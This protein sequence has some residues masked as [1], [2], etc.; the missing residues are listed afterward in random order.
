MKN[1]NSNIFSELEF[2]HHYQLNSSSETV[3]P[4]DKKDVS[5]QATTAT[6]THTS[7]K[8]IIAALGFIA[9]LLLFSG[10]QLYRSLNLNP[11]SDKIR[12]SN[13][14]FISNTKDFDTHNLKEE[15][16]L[17]EFDNFIDLQKNEMSTIQNVISQ[18]KF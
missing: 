9:T 10:M 15:I 5:S 11:A 7:E 12:G 17:K 18:G 14:T 3:S 13:L 2:S 8:S 1:N 4:I 6:H 16:H